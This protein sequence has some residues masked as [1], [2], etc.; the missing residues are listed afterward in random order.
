[1]DGVGEVRDGDLLLKRRL[2]QGHLDGKLSVRQ[3]AGAR[4]KWIEIL[5]ALSV[6][7]LQHR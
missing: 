6:E 7:G 2:W 3:T 4:G 5:D 1:M